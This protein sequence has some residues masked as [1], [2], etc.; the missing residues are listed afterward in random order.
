MPGLACDQLREQVA[1]AE[2]VARVKPQQRP[3]QRLAVLGL[4]ETPCADHQPMQAAQKRAVIN[5]PPREHTI[6]ILWQRLLGDPDARRV[7]RERSL[8]IAGGKREQPEMRVRVQAPRIPLRDATQHCLRPLVLPAVAQRERLPDHIP[9]IRVITARQ[10]LLELIATPRA[11]SDH[12][13]ERHRDDTARLAQDSSPTIHIPRSYNR[14]G[15]PANSTAPG[16]S[17]SPRG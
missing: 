13:H 7:M 14:S 17:I 4:A 5:P 3:A 1:R 8:D 9:S 2:M 11:P 16:G 15:A 6:E 10:Q 12:L